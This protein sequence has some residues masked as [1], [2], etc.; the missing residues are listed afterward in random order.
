MNYQDIPAEIQHHCARIDKA[1]KELHQMSALNLDDEVRLNAYMEVGETSM[2]ISFNE[3]EAIMRTLIKNSEERLV[4]LRKI[5][6]VL[7]DTLESI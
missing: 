6:N 1:K 3:K 5:H 7:V 4:K 2:K